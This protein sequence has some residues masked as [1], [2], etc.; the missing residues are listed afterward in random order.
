MLSFVFI[1][2]RLVE[3]VLPIRGNPL[4]PRTRHDSF[5]YLLIVIIGTLVGRMRLNNSLSRLGPYLLP[6][7]TE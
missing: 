1:Y 2:K 4:I 7:Q 3:S 6:R 5:R